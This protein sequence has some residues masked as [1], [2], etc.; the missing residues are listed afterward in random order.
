MAELS[1]NA[2][3]LTCSTR[4]AL[5]RDR[6]QAR[7]AGGARAPL[8]FTVNPRTR[9]RLRV[10]HGRL[11]SF[12]A[13]TEGVRRTA[14]G[15]A[16]SHILPLHLDGEHFEAA[17]PILSA[18]LRSMCAPRP[19]WKR[20]RGAFD[21]LMALDVLPKLLCTLVVLLADKG[22]HA[23][24]ALL[25]AYTSINRLLIAR[26][27]LAAAA[28]RGRPPRARVH[29]ER[30]ARTEAE[31]NLGTLIPLLALA[32][33]TRWADL[34]WPPHEMLDRGVLWA[35]R[36]HPEPPPPASGG[37]PTAAPTSS[38]SSGC[39][40]EAR[41]RPALAATTSASSRRWRS[42]PSTSRR[43]PR[44]LL[45]VAP[46][47]PPH[48]A[49]PRRRLVARL[50]R[51]AR[52]PLPQPALVARLK[53]AVARPRRK[54]TTPRAWTSASPPL[55]RVGDPAQGRERRRARRCGAS[56][57]ARCGARGGRN[58]YLDASCPPRLRDDALARPPRHRLLVDAL[59]HRRVGGGGYRSNAAAAWRSRIRATSSTVAAARASTRSTSTCAR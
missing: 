48:P 47:H 18:Q 4:G 12:S 33:G 58:F 5:G 59:G 23:S 43:L 21:P 29:R 16:F 11:V 10:R 56:R 54:G 13:F 40:R 27:P 35:C 45:A 9:D 53:A 51:G 7:R 57:C 49:R 52:V 34:A 25:D 2:S 6:R 15:E 28:R 37:R 38:A 8:R 32:G 3:E 19:S 20:A 1:S 26:R 46:R 22:V 44:P 24:D 41:E 36:E 42:S 50:L 17:L 39:G 30:E 31:P 14:W 55:G